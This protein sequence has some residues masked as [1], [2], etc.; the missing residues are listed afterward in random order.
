VGSSPPAAIDDRGPIRPRGHTNGRVGA[1]LPPTS[2]PFVV[3]S[4][5][6]QRHSDSV[7]LCPGKA[8]DVSTTIIGGG[9]K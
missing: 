4:A 8:R 6:S 3:E 5:Q 2:L 7:T 1:E 9:S